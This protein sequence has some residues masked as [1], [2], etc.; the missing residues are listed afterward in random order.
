MIKRATQSF[1]YN[2][3]CSLTSQ[4]FLYFLVSFE[5]WTFWKL[6]NRVVI[7]ERE[8]F[9]SIGKK[10]DMESPIS[11]LVPSQAITINSVKLI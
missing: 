4:R 10:E 8:K 9:A 6:V 7:R 2:L 5:N 1:E 3:H 11:S